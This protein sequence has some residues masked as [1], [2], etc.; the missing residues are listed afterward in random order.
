M[1][2]GDEPFVRLRGAVVVSGRFPLLSGVDLDVERAS[3]TVLTGANGAG[4]TSLL[5]LLGGLV[6]LS[7]GEG[8]VAGVDLA[9]GDRR[10]LR[11]RVGW[12]GHEGSFYDD[13]SARENLTFAARALRLPVGGLDEALARVGLERRAAT[14]SRALSA[15]QRRRLA[16]A[17]LLLRRAEL[18]L[19]DEPYAALDDE[20]RRL[21]D[22]VIDAAM[23][24]GATVVV[25]A[26]Q[27]LGVRRP[28][29]LVNLVGGRVEGAL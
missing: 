14:P 3:L 29:T 28:A 13:L 10:E 26:H 4:K 12:L 20:A 9:R 17:W 2:A 5:R 15:G 23:A 21:F 18:W 19:L 22:D 8:R 11:R 24:G 6:A 25:S 1:R 7:A 27:A 16:L